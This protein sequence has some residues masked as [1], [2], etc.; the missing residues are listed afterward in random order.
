MIH[1]Y[2]ITID[3][4]YCQLY[5]DCVVKIYPNLQCAHMYHCEPTTSPALNPCMSQ[6]INKSVIITTGDTTNA[7][8]E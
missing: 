8:R 7:T 2:R 3:S 5:N 6:M 4:D 1:Y